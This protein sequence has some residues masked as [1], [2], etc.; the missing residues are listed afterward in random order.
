MTDYSFG[1]WLYRRVIVTDGNFSMQNMYMKK[2]LDDVALTL[3]EGYSVEDLPYRAHLSESIEYNQVLLSN[4]LCSSGQV[5]NNWSS[6]IYMPKS[7]SS[8]CRR[9]NVLTFEGDW[10]WSVRLWQTWLLCPT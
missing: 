10:G 4:G 9:F 6:E 5:I 1:S 3:N 7:Q 8:Q 2:P